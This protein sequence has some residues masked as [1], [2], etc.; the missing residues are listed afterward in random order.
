MKK[1][2]LS[3]LLV[4]ILVLGLTGCG[5]N[6]ELSNKD[7]KNNSNSKTIEKEKNKVI[8]CTLTNKN[9]DESIRGRKSIF[10]EDKLKKDAYRTFK[11]NL[12]F[13]FI[14]TNLFDYLEKENILSKESRM[15]IRTG[16]RLYYRDVY[17][18][19]RMDN[20]DYS[21]KFEEEAKKNLMFRTLFC[22]LDGTLSQLRV[23][24]YLNSVYLHPEYPI[25]LD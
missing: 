11:G 7:N 16:T 25:L 15:M 21:E 24:E 3:I 6:K 20:P 5:N 1:K 18:K 17:I 2:I 8:T 14:L 22:M 19:R 13:S 12:F 23:D 10:E 9:A 4:G